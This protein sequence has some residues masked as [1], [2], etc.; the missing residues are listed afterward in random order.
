[1]RDLQ[2]GEETLL[3]KV[4]ASVQMGEEDRA[5]ALRPALEQCHSDVEKQERLVEELLEA[6]R[7]FESDWPLEF[8]MHPNQHGKKKKKKLSKKGGK[9]KGGSGNKKKGAAAAGNGGGG[10]VQEEAAEPSHYDILNQTK[11][12][13]QSKID[14]ANEAGE[15]DIVNALFESQRELQREM[16][17]L[18]QENMVHRCVSFERACVQLVSLRGVASECGICV[19]VEFPVN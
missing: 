9:D 2:R 13:L 1:M 14:V 12:T 7:A 4:K 16:A 8:N 15:R 6:E 3:A 19:L 18:R 10:G 5:A 17:R 11:T